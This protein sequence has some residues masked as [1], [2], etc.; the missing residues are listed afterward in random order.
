[1]RS[2]IGATSADTLVLEHH[3]ALPASATMETAALQ[4][5]LADC[6]LNA[7]ANETPIRDAFCDRGIL[8]GSDCTDT[9]SY[10]VSTCDGTTVVVTPGMISGHIQS[11]KSTGD[12]NTGGTVEVS[13]GADVTFEATT[14]VQLNPGFTVNPGGE[15]T[16]QIGPVGC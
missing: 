9:P 14:G 11:F 13:S 16:V 4:V 3:F 10:C 8:G 12:L 5:L 2:S 7:F 15:F 1:M 6:S